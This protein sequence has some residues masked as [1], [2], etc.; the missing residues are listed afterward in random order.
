MSNECKSEYFLYSTPI[1]NAKNETPIMTGG[2]CKV[3]VFFATENRKADV[4]P[5]V[6]ERL[7]LSF[8]NAPISAKGKFAPLR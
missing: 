7:T 3:R 6:M 5:C 2:G 4:F 1:D 8:Q